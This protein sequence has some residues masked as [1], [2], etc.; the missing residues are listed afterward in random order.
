MIKNN[1]L[2]G[3][4]VHKRISPIRHKLAYRVFALMLNCDEFQDL[5]KKT[6]L[7]SYNRFNL[8]SIHDKDHGDGRPIQD[9]LE[10][11]KKNVIT[12]EPVVNFS[13]IAYPRVFGYVFNPITIY[14]GYN[15]EKQIELVIYE[16]N[17][18]FG[19]RIIYVI[20]VAQNTGD[21]I[22]QKCEK[23]LFISPFNNN[24]GTYS[25]HIKNNP[26][27]F[28][29]GINLHVR[30]QPILVAHFTGQKQDYS[31]SNLLKSLGKNLLLTFKVILAIH[32]E[33]LKLF[34]KGMSFKK[35]PQAPKLQICYI[36][37]TEGT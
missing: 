30:N 23:K 7:F 18:T 36:E 32:Y 4:V 27:L 14:L 10:E 9:F 29:I 33:A 13:M 34:F 2:V 21:I 35:K 1:I 24:E 12:R 15:K 5:N 19:Q 37:T 16:V 3:K 8:F 26:N 31:S 17:N 20:P 6:S 28:Q 22:H 11:I 25:F